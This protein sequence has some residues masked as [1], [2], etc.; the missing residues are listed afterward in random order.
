MIK[1]YVIDC[2][3]HS[4]V[5]PTHMVQ[6]RVKFGT[7]IHHTHSSVTLFSIQFTRFYSMFFQLSIVFALIYLNYFLANRKI[8][9]TTVE[10]VGQTE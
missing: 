8:Q 2:L 1:I 9:L 7:Q 3:T 10:P 6:Y 5:L 4:Q